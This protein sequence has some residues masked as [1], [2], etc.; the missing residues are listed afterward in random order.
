[1][2]VCA[3]RIPRDIPLKVWT[4]ENTYRALEAVAESR[5]ISLSVLI[6]EAIRM[7]RAVRKELT[8][9]QSQARAESG[10]AAPYRPGAY[11]SAAA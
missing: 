9:Q 4:D 8:E 11:R 10:S 7:H 5:V 1:M 6:H 2:S 3:A